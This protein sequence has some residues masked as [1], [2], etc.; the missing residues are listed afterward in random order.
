MLSPTTDRPTYAS[1]PEGELSS[2]S[3]FVR[4]FLSYAHQGETRSGR[5][6]ESVRVV[7]S[8]KPRF[9]DA[10]D[11]LSCVYYGIVVHGR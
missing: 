10:W 7:A 6:K 4:E 1:S 9:G 2:V 5:K 3:I 11:E 8:G